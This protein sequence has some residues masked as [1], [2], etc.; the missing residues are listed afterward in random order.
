MTFFPKLNRLGDNFF[1][2]RY[3]VF[4]F[5]LY[6]VDISVNITATDLRKVPFESEFNRVPYLFMTFFRILNR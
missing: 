1:G 2:G 4:L 3:L 5:F 6:F